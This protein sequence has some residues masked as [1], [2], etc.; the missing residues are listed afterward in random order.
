MSKS[1]CIGL[2][3]GLT[4]IAC[5]SASGQPPAGKG[6][7]RF[8]QTFT[9]K[10]RDGEKIVPGDEKIFGKFD[11][12]ML[13]RTWSDAIHGDTW[14]AIRSVNP[15]AEIFIQTEGPTLWKEFDKSGIRDLKDVGRYDISR[16]HSMGAIN[17]DHPEFFLLDK[18]GKRCAAYESGYKDRYL[19]DFGSGDYQRYWVEAITADVL[20]QPWRGTGIHIDNIGPLCTFP[21]DKPAKYD[22]DEKWCK[23]TL[24]FVDTVAGAMHKQGCRVWINAGGTDSDR[25]WKALVQLDGL[26]NRPDV[27]GEEGAF[28]ISSGKGDTRFPA[29]EKWKHSVDFLSQLRKSRQAY[30]SHTKLRR[31]GT[32]TDNY[33]KPVTFWQSLWYAMCSFLL[34][35]DD[36]LNNAYFFFSSRPAGGYGAKNWWFEEYEQIDLGQAAG[37]YRIAEQ[38]GANVYWREFAKGYVFVNP[39]EKDAMGI[40]LPGPSKELSHD[41]FKRDPQTLANSN[42]LDLLAHHGTILLKAK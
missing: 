32:G 23:A 11:M 19:M 33:G 8:I 5:L 16:G 40:L 15:A 36:Q 2:V 34:G 27:V 38:G 26:P 17:K 7:G 28:A 25:G 10:L 3:I 42:K 1:A 37:S 41:N 24:S 9:V 20:K 39:T 31:D 35:K 22:T 30:F 18:N 12:V 29:E 14:K 21:T 6:H 4:G 13:T